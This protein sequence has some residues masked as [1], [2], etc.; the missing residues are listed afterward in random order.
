[1][2]RRAFALAAAIAA[3]LL[4]GCGSSSG[5]GVSDGQLVAALGLTMKDGHYVIDKN[6]FCSIDRLLH[7]S[8]EVSD[9]A[10]SKLV[11]AS[12]DATVGIEVL[13]PFAPSCRREAEKALTKLSRKASR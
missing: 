5:G 10:S 6:P 11:I 1:M 4:G 8:G 7:D 9:A 3:L 13:T 12:K 2:K